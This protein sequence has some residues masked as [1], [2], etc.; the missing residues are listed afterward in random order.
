[1]NFIILLFFSIAG[2]L[3]KFGDDL[4]DVHHRG[5][6]ANIPLIITAIL[7]GLLIAISNDSAAI[8]ISI[9]LGVL[10]S[11]KI[12]SY[13]YI[14]GVAIIIATPVIVGLYYEP[15]L[16]RIILLLLI[17]TAMGILDEKGDSISEKENKWYILQYRPFMKISVIILAVLNLLYWDVA[18]GFLL[19]DT[20]Y[21]L[22]SKLTTQAYAK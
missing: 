7:L 3:L 12:D 13:Q 5:E 8:V 17:L 15:I 4:I 6:I 20:F 11:S 10:F 14:I 18:L 22:A 9:I 19:F 16:P 2:F 1:M 21:I